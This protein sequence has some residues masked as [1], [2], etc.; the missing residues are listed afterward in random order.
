MD[1]AKKLLILAAIAIKT[2]KLT[3]SNN[4]RLKRRSEIGYFH[5]TFKTIYELTPHELPKIIRLNFMQFENLVKVAGSKLI[6][7]SIREPISPR[8]RLVMTLRYLVTGSSINDLAISF[9]VGA[10]TAKNIIKE[11]MVVIWDS[12]RYFLR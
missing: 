8:E 5:T 4:P 6:K 7:L 12:L 10:T 3:R 9:D 2:K 1:K 11:T